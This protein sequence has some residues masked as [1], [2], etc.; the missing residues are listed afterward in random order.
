MGPNCVICYDVYNLSRCDPQ[1][2]AS[3]HERFGRWPGGRPPSGNRQRVTQAC[4]GSSFPNS[5]NIA[6]SFTA[7]H[8]FSNK[9][10]YY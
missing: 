5:I 2:A 3:T 4:F 10:V 8:S 9:S 6:N 7:A 1:Q